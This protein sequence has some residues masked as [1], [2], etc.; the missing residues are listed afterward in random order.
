M[1]MDNYSGIVLGFHLSFTARCK[2]VCGLFRQ[3]R[4]EGRG[5]S[6]TAVPHVTGIY[7]PSAVRENVKREGEKI[8]HV[9]WVGGVTIVESIGKWAGVGTASLCRMDGSLR[10]LDLNLSQP[11]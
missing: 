9:A 11:R 10:T 4:L 6:S 3:Y 1:N 5:K 2:G 8:G 7:K